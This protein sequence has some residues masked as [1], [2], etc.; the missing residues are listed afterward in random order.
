IDKMCRGLDFIQTIVQAIASGSPFQLDLTDILKSLSSYQSSA[1]D[2]E[3]P[4]PSPSAGHSV[5]PLVLS[6]TCH[7]ET[8]PVDAT[9]PS[10]EYNPGLDLRG[11]ANKFQIETV[12]IETRLLDDLMTQ[13]GELVV[14]RTQAARNL[15]NIEEMLSFLEDFQRQGDQQAQQPDRPGSAAPVPSREGSEP[16]NGNHRFSDHILDKLESLKKDFYQSSSHLETV[17]NKLQEGIRTIRLVP[18]KTLFNYFPRMVRDLAREQ[19]KEVNLIIEGGETTADK[20]VL[21]EMKD[22][23]MHLLRNS[24]DHGLE[25]PEDRKKQGKPAT[26]S[27]RLKAYRQSEKVVIEVEDDGRG[28]DLETIK[29]VALEKHLIRE[30]DLSELTPAQIQSMV[31]SAGFTTRTFISSISGRGVGLDVVKANVENLKGTVQVQSDSNPGFTRFI[32]QLPV[33]LGTVRVLT[34]KSGNQIFAI[35]V[36]N[37]KLARQVDQSDIFRIKGRPAIRFEE[38]AVF[39]ESLET[40]LGLTKLSETKIPDNRPSDEAQKIGVI[41]TVNGV[42]MGI[43]VDEVQSEQEVVLKP[44]SPILKQVK[45]ISGATILETGRVC[46]ILNPSELLV[47]LKNHK[48]AITSTQPKK[49]PVKK[50]SLLLV[51]DSITTRTQEKRILEGAGYEVTVAVDG[52]DAWNKLNS[53]PVEGVVTDIQMPNMDGFALTE[54]IRKDK[55]YHELPIILVTAM[56]SEENK[57]RGLLV[58]AN[59]YICKP[60]FDQQVLLDTLSRLI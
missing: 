7:P 55:R 53:Q 40:L 5:P 57:K 54:K 59:A 16:V 18:L 31:F 23:L 3:P 49:V 1:T 46:M 38:S 32:I 15:K 30:E 24:I 60:S 47:S 58:G 36:E 41:L 11:S 21:E 6:E 42:F 27:I 19:G 20:R 10:T 14:T 39:I 45:S 25:I 56:D 44:Q 34:V 2:D 50:K 33:T 22:P 51:E 48:G 17:S 29:S 9:P 26:G 35:P 13:V 4:P 37:V 52:V 12:R 28:M 8:L 43:L